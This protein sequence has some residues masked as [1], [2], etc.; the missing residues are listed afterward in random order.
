MDIG[1]LVEELARHKELETVGGRPYLFSLT[2]GMPFPLVIDNH[3]RIVKDKSALRRLMSLGNS[4]IARAADQS[5]FAV[6]IHEWLVSELSAERARLDSGA[7]GELALLKGI[8]IVEQDPPFILDDHI[9]DETLLGIHG[10]GG[11]GK[12]T[13]AILLLA[14]LSVGKIP[15]TL[16][17][18]EPRNVLVLSN[19]DSAGRIRKLFKAAGGDLKRLYVENLNDTWTLAD[20]PRLERTISS[21]NITAAVIDSLASHSGKADLNSHGE[22]TA[23]LIPLRAIAERQRSMIALIHHLNKSASVDHLQKIAGSVGIAASIRHNLH[24]A[25]DPDNPESRLL[26]N[27]KSNLCPPNVPA[28]RFKLFPVS[29]EGESAIT[30]QQV[31]EPAASSGDSGAV[32]RAAD[33]LAGI[34][35]QGSR[36]QSEVMELA[37]GEGISEATLR[38]AK[39]SLNVCSR[40]A[41]YG[42][43]WFWWLPEENTEESAE[44]VQ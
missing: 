17:P 21:H 9:P 2:E 23:M 13:L 26:L 39:T 35:A 19:E 10:P 34:L 44:R 15:F 18:C 11:L 41:S 14:N 12:T 38:R 43:G 1:T 24:V 42:G 5:E 40:K 30:I 32:G 16:A 36:E 28:L 6:D 31:Y 7:S 37:K 27:G 20:H 3:I 29:W 33:W 22:T 25:V 8:E 4:I